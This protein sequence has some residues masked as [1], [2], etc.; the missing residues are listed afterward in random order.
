MSTDKAH[1]ARVED[2]RCGCGAAGPC[3]EMDG[4]VNDIG[5]VCGGAAGC[6]SDAERFLE[7]LAQGE[8]HVPSLGG[9][10]VGGLIV[11]GHELVALPCVGPCVEDFEP[12]GEAHVA[13]QVDSN[14]D[15][16]CSVGV[17]VL[18]VE[19]G[20]VAL[21]VKDKGA[22]NGGHDIQGGA[23]LFSGKG[24][25]SFDQDGFDEDFVSVSV[26]WAVSLCWG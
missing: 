22:E 26:G 25:G 5:N 17:D 21:L 20:P 10:G 4:V 13:E 11:E 7:L 6:E 12:G 14:V 8:G 3:E 9:E 1:A 18:A 23:V 16:G 2:V 24:D 19:C 15:V